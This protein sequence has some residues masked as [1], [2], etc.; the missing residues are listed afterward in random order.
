MKKY[1]FKRKLY[2][3]GWV[4][5]S[6]Q[7]WL[8]TAAFLLFIIVIASSFTPETTI[9]EAIGALVVPALLLTAICFVTGE[10]PKWQWGERVEDEER[11][12]YTKS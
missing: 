1:W 10:R 2:G 11:K 4:P 12:P 6:W 8:V 5:S 7:G 3:W 9:V